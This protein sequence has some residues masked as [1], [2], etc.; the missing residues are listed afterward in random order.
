MLCLPVGPRCDMCELSQ[1]G[2]CPSAQK[3]VKSTKRK[4]VVLDSP[5]K[6]KVELE[7]DI[8]FPNPPIDQEAM[9]Q[10]EPMTKEE[11]DV[12]LPITKLKEET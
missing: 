11:E 8:K 6:V 10:M 2:L 5:A 12:D 7:E 3:V 4:A 9:I 1:K